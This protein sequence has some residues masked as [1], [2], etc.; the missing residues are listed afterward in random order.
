MPRAPKTLAS[1]ETN[2]GARTSFTVGRLQT[3]Q[4]SARRC[5]RLGGCELDGR[6]GGALAVVAD[7]TLRL[8]RVVR[9]KVLGPT[10]ADRLV[11]QHRL[12]PQRG[13]GRTTEADAV[14]HAIA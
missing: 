4:F 8:G 7:E 13:R 14:R 5:R 10:E 1:D 11:E 9:A 6:A 12:D 2:T 3:T